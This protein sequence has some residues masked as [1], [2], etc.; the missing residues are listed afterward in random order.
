[1]TTAQVYEALGGLAPGGVEQGE[2]RRKSRTLRWVEA[3]S[4]EPVV[5]FGGGAGEPASLAW[6]AVMPVLAQRTRVVV[7]D[8][9]GLGGSDPAG[10]LSL[11]QAL[12]DLLAVAEAVGDRPRL[13]VGH[14]WGGL[15]A[16]LAACQ[17]PELTCGLVL[18]DPADERYWQSLPA[19]LLRMD[20]EAGESFLREWEQG[21]LAKSIQEMAR[22]YARELTDDSALQQRVLDAYASCYHTADQAGVFLA[23]TRTALAAIPEISSLRSTYPVPNIPMIVLS[24][25]YG[26]SA[27]YRAV[28]TRAH[29]GLVEHAP[30]AAHVVVEDAGH[31]IHQE[32]PAEVI[33]AIVRVLE[34]CRAA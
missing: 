26:P 29:A 1:V 3:G 11:A 23:E 4:G 17:Y 33:A 20:E 7:Y 22:P 10:E 25:T 15:L 21:R 27:E 34:R 32:R 14:S 16:L 28:W 5:I 12:A 9:A 6:A 30:Q 31:S 18:V 13:L 19:E 2:V 24:A 8:R